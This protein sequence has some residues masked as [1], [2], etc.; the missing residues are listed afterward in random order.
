MKKIFTISLLIG[1]VFVARAQTTVGSIISTN[2][3]WNAAGSPYL[4]MQNTNITK[5][6]SVKIMPG[7]TVLGANGVSIIVDGELQALGKS[8]SIIHT[9]NIRLKYNGG[10][11]D[12]NA[13][14]RA[15]ALLR[16][17]EMDST[18]NDYMLNV[19]AVTMR[20]E[21]CNF[22]TS[23]FGI[24]F[25]GATSDADLFEILNCN[26]DKKLG[27][28][29]DLRAYGPARFLVKGCQI[30]EYRGSSLISG[31]FEFA[32][33][34]VNTSSGM[35]FSMY[36]YGIIQCNSFRNMD[37]VDIST[38]S[39][40]DTG[41]YLIVD[42][43]TFDSMGY[44]SYPMVKISDNIDKFY[45]PI[46]MRVTRNNFLFNKGQKTKLEFY[47]SNPDLT[48]FKLINCKYNYWGTTDS[49]QIENDIRDYTDD[50]T[51]FAEADYSGYLFSKDTTCGK[52]VDTSCRAHFTVAIDSTEEGEFYVI[53]NSTHVDADTKYD[54][55]F[56][57]IKIKNTRLPNFYYNGTGKILVCL[58][59]YNTKTQCNSTFCDSVGYDAGTTDSGFTIQ[60]LGVEDFNSTKKF[61]NF[62][63]NAAVTVY[64]NPAQNEVNILLTQELK[65]DPEILVYNMSG[66][67]V[68]HIQLWQT[69][70][71]FTLNTSNLN[72]GIYQVVVRSNKNIA[73]TKLVLNK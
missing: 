52:V 22:L 28:S 38:T 12:F 26:F 25:M 15:G 72:S 36:K 27:Q 49:A 48:K 42:G 31:A 66:A 34:T 17:V 61:G 50:I 64:P 9:K 62:H 14:T 69:A 47:G 29:F 73:S 4:V 56:W 6:T 37:N 33:N 67:I 57:N 13:S 71:G 18:N 55:T 46:S 51:V 5:G 7:T 24:T 11:V 63:N 39:S 19:T 35:Y 54:W 68:Q 40:M 8:D 30:M 3:V 10:S 44:Y 2:Q 41:R 23:L 43:N 45:P 20:V 16:Y 32:N 60:A 53:E 70:V 58:H 21:H 59:I 1:F 65:K